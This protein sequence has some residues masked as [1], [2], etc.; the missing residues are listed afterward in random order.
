MDEYNEPRSG[1][2]LGRLFVNFLTIITLL[3]TLGIGVAFAVV[4]MNP[5]VSFNPFPPPTYP[6]MLETPTAV[7]TLESTADPQITATATVE[8]LATETSTPILSTETPTEVGL[9]ETPTEVGLTETPTEVGPTETPTEVPPTET[10]TALPT[11]VTLTPT[12]FPFGLQAGSIAAT[13]SW[14]HGCDWMGV[15]GHV[16]DTDNSPLTGYA[17]QL[18]GELD[19]VPQNMELLSG[20]ASEILGESGYIFDLASHPIASEETLWMQ[21]VDA[22]SELPLSEKIWLTTY[23]VCSKNFLLVNWRRLP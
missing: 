6:P 4:Y 19:G 13:T 12:P 20:S 1:F 22:S 21:L 23:D 9:T 16:L 17:I 8:D 15:G 14:F 18:G 11:T 10:P 5:Q 3:A 7:P 2:S